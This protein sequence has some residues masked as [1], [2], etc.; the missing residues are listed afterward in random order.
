MNQATMIVKIK[1]QNDETR[2]DTRNGFM[3][4]VSQEVIRIY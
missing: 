2:D 4:E 1:H 3:K